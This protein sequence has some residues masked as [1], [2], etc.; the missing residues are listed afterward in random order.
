MS[1]TIQVRRGKGG[2][3]TGYLFRSSLSHTLFLI[4]ITVRLKEDWQRWLWPTAEGV[5]GVPLW[6]K[7]SDEV[8]MEMEMAPGMLHRVLRSLLRFKIYIY[9][10][11]IYTY[12]IYYTL[13]F[14]FLPP[15]P[16][17]PSWN[18][19]LQLK[20]QRLWRT[21]QTLGH[22]RYNLARTRNHSCSMRPPNLLCQN[23]D[24]V[25]SFKNPY[26][27]CV[28]RRIRYCTIVTR[29][30]FIM[31][32]WVLVFYT[33]IVNHNSYIIHSHRLDCAH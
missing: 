22:Q 28:V 2:V 18:H 19:A 1:P 29:T 16:L 5:M 10:I 15:S 9:N 21:L 31:E 24:S 32:S 20:V 23:L 30:P 12:V 8:I 17:E 26:Y 13:S 14:V 6:T 3:V 4:W 33:K 7:V 27:V 11:Y 25:R